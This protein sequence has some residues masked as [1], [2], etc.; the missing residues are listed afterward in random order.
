GLDKLEP[1]QVRE[2]VL[3]LERGT[4]RLTQLID[5]LLESV[6]I[7]AGQLA[8]RK[9][10]VSLETVVEDARALIGSL[11]TSRNQTLD[12]SIPEDLPTIEGDALRLT[13][14]LVNLITNASKFAPEGSTIR[15]GAKARG[16]S[17]EDDPARRAKVVLWIED[18]GPGVPEGD[19]DAIFGRFRRGAD[20]EPEPGGLGLG[21][22]IVK[23]I[24]ARHGGTIEAS[25]TPEE[26]TRFT[27]TLNASEGDE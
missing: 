10:N 5:N 16:G 27:I 23:S 15:I 8:I 19:P 2:L 26:R 25:R 21:L 11:L 4:V 13:Q 1:G 9:Q 7:E 18:E 24:V 14:V 20:I 6:R 17:R 12:V 22:W 3:S